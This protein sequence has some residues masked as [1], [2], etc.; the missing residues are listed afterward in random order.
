MP[1]CRDADIVL[2]CSAAHGSAFRDQI[3]TDLGRAK[4]EDM[5]TKL[6]VCQMINI[7]ILKY[8]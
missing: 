7:T 4:M 1:F 8:E 2:T 3:N 6:S 5:Q